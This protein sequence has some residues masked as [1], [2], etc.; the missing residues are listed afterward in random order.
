MCTAFIP[1]RNFISLIKFPLREEFF[2]NSGKHKYE[3]C[4]FTCAYFFIHY[5]MMY[6]LMEFGIHVQKLNFVQ[7]Y[8]EKTKIKT[9][10]IMLVTQLGNIKNTYV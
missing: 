6:A 4:V 2:L 1:Q 9:Y 3:N 7:P 10:K 8:K 5:S